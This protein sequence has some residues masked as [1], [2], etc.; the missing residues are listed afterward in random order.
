MSA[1]KSHLCMI[2]WP[3]FVILWP[4]ILEGILLPMLHSNRPETFTLELISQIWI[5]TAMVIGLGLSFDLDLVEAAVVLLFGFAVH[6]TLELRGVSLP[7][8]ILRLTR[9]YKLSSSTDLIKLV[10]DITGLVYV[11]FMI[12]VCFMNHHWTVTEGYM[13]RR[14]FFL[15][16]KEEVVIGQGRPVMYTID[17]VI[18]WI[19][20]L[21]GGKLL[22]FDPDKGIRTIGIVFFVKARDEEIDA[23][24]EKTL[25]SGGGHH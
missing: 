6:Y 19:L 13:R 22:A 2:S 14:R 8:E 9:E 11:F 15:L 12:P 7:A 10:G 23:K 1:P 21:G 24:Y 5:G 17:N 18:I 4:L 3:R 20:T 16:G 25:V